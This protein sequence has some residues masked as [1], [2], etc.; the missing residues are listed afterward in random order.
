MRWEE[1]VQGNGAG[2]QN[3]FQENKAYTPLRFFSW[4]LHSGVLE[5]I[6]SFGI[7]VCL[8]AIVCAVEMCMV[9][10]WIQVKAIYTI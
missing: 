5:M 7:F 2:L 3:A 8:D 9:H 6:S 1:A 4:L 10:V